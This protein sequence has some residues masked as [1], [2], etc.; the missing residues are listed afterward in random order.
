MSS[1]A[2]SKMAIEVFYSYSHRDERL[3]DLL[4]TH[5]SLLKRE[6]LISCWYDRRIGPGENWSNEIDLH[7]RTAQI[8]LLL[9]SSD[10]IASDYCYLKEM[11]Q[12]LRR[13]RAGTARVVPIILRPTDWHSAPFGKLQ[14]LPKDGKPVTEWPNPD[15]AF[16]D[17]VKGIRKAVN[18]LVA[19]AQQIKAQSPHI[20]RKRRGTAATSQKVIIDFANSP[21]G[22]VLRNK[23]TEVREVREQLSE[24]DL[25]RVR[26][27]IIEKCRKELGDC[28]KEIRTIRKM[29]LLTVVLEIINDLNENIENTV[30]EL[31]VVL[32]FLDKLRTEDFN[33]SLIAD[34][35]REVDIGLNNSQKFLDEAL[36]AA[37]NLDLIIVQVS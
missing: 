1:R 35:A 11:K 15:S 34:R 7:L 37:S 33:A 9:V 36:I 21:E 6:G 17:I 22:A 25:R 24:T 19:S 27:E 18:D 2:N 31:N 10:F 30:R 5:L 16:L 29:K 28:L 32:F 8:I 12:A 20:V 3:R 13:H 23:I 26:E 14:A 4:E